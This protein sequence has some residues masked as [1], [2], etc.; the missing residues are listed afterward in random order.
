V[1]KALRFREPL[2]LGPA[3]DPDRRKR[4]LPPT[5]SLEEHIEDFVGWMIAGGFSPEEAKR[6]G[7][8]VREYHRATGKNFLTLPPEEQVAFV[9]ECDRR[10]DELERKEAENLADFDPDEPEY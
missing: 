6:R 10:I 9:V 1:E 5:A 3:P 4:D 7:E 2:N 8:W